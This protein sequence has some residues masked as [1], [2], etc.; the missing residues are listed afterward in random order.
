MTVGI[1]V[2]CENAK[3]AVVVADRLVGF[4]ALGIDTDCIKLTNPAPEF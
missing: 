4:G 1:A 2:L 3:S